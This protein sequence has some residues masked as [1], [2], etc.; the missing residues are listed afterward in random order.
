MKNHTAATKGIL[1]YCARCRMTTWQRRLAF[2]G[3]WRCQ[4][5]EQAEKARKA[6]YGKPVDSR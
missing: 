1:K 5:C 2:E 4:L 6:N 3:R